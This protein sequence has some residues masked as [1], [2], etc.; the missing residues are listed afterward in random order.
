MSG[1]PPT[2]SWT[3]V[4]QRRHPLTRSVLRQQGAC[5][6]LGGRALCRSF[7]SPC[8]GLLPFHCHPPRTFPQR[9]QSAQR[10]LSTSWPP[11]PSFSRT[12]W[13]LCPPNRKV[14]A[15]PPMHRKAEW[16]TRGT[17]NNVFQSLLR[18]LGCHKKISP[19]VKDPMWTA[20]VITVAPWS[21]A[22]D[23]QLPRCGRDTEQRARRIG[24]GRASG[25]IRDLEIPRLLGAAPCPPTAPPPVPSPSPWSTPTAQPGSWPD[26]SPLFV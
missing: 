3:A 14:P 1:V 17:K 12:P 25:L 26:N 19:V 21:Q 18:L 10:L 9:P 15:A 5:S 8:P 23:G 22:G 4:S 2:A 20:P 16:I 13:P 7:Q 6:A 24:A 11:G